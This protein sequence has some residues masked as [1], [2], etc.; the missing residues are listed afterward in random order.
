MKKKGLSFC[1]LSSLRTLAHKNSDGCLLMTMWRSGWARSSTPPPACFTNSAGVKKLPW[2]THTIRTSF[3]LPNLYR[4]PSMRRALGHS[5]RENT[6]GISSSIIVLRK[7]PVLAVLIVSDRRV[8]SGGLAAPEDGVGGRDDELLLF[9]P[10][11]LSEDV[12]MADELL[13]SAPPLPLPPASKNN[14]G[15]ICQMLPLEEYI[16]HSYLS[17]Y[18]WQVLTV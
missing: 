15:N 11:L 9:W 10:L 4:N 18:Y 14:K 2:H 3:A 12:F 17:V 5:S 6:I 7:S 16:T 1:C 8:R 13:V